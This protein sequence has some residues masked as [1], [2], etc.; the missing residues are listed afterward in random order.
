M[1][2]FTKWF[3]GEA[4]PYYVLNS[5]LL[6][7]KGNECFCSTSSLVP[8]MGG[9]DTRADRTRSTLAILPM[10]GPL[11]RSSALPHLARFQCTRD[12][13]SLSQQMPGLLGRP[14]DPREWVRDLPRQHH[15]E[16]GPRQHR[17]HLQGQSPW[18]WSLEPSVCQQQCNEQERNKTS[19]LWRISS[20]GWDRA[21]L[22]SRH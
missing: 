8:T 21:A 13:V 20:V 22:S 16:H 9:V 3:Q 11:G 14:E 6:C 18:L 4:S 5:V 17:H 15:A 19:R 2:I 10:L 7:A 1:G 12:R